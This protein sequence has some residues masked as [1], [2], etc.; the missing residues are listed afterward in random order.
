MS[1]DVHNLRGAAETKARKT[2]YLKR[3]ALTIV[4]MLP[5]NPEDARAVLEYAKLLV[6]FLNEEAGETGANVR[7]LRPS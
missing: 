1:M 5:E 3:Q 4:S 6:V 2:V 7:S